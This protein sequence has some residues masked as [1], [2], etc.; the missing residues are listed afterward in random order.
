[1]RAVLLG[2]ISYIGMTALSGGP[3]WADVVTDGTMGRRG[4]VRGG[5]DVTVRAGLGQLRGTNLFHS[6]ER[7]G[8][9]EGGKVTFTGPDGVT[10]VIAR[11]TGGE[12]SDILGTLASTMPSADFF[13]INPAGILFGPNAKLDLK[14]SFHASTADQLRLADGAVFSAL[15]TAGSTLSVAE[16][17]SFGFLGAA[18]GRITLDRGTLAVAPGRHLSLSAGEVALSGGRLVAGDDPATTTVEPGGRITLAG[19]DSGTLDLR[20]GDVG[21][22]TGGSVHLS[23]GA[24]L[25]ASGDGGGA[26]RIRATDISLAEQS[27]IFASSLGDRPA[28]DGIDVAGSRLT[29]G[30]GSIIAA[31]VGRLASTSKD[32]TELPAIAAAGDGGRI[33][34]AVTEAR[35]DGGSL[36]RSTSF[37][38][39]AAGGIRI[40]A[41]NP[42]FGDGYLQLRSGGRIR[43][44]AN[45]GS[46]GNA[47]SIDV[48]VHGSLLIDAQNA[49]DPTDIGSFA[50]KDSQGYGGSISVEAHRVELVHRGEIV[51]VTGGSRAGGGITMSAGSLFLGD[52]GQ[53]KSTTRGA[54]D[55]GSIAIVAGEVRIDGVGEAEARANDR[56]RQTR[57]YSGAEAGSSGRGGTIALRVADRL[58]LNDA[59]EISSTTDRDSR[60]AAGSITI[61]AGRLYAMANGYIRA[62]TG[63]RM[64][65]GDVGIVAD[66]VTLANGGRITS[67][68]VE[69]AGDS[70]KI[71]LEA[72]QSLSLEDG[73]IGVNSTAGGNAGS[74]VIATPN[75]MLSGGRIRSETTA[76]G[77]AGRI[78]ISTGADGALSGTVSIT[79]SKLR[80]SEVTASTRGSGQGGQVS[81]RTGSLTMDGPAIAQVD[82]SDAETRVSSDASFRGRAGAV[83]VI[84]RD[85]VIG[86]GARISSGTDGAG[87][88]GNVSL[89]ATSITL[90]GGNVSSSS[91]GTLA[92][93]G[94]AGSIAITA[95]RSIL[96]D[97]GR[98]ASSSEGPGAGG[99]VVVRALDGGTVRLTEGGTIAASGTGAGPAGAVTV[100]A[101]IVEA[102]DGAIT[103]ASN[104][105]GGSIRVTAS[106][107]AYLRR[108]RIISD[109]I[110]PTSGASIVRVD[111]PV[112]VLSDSQ[113]SS[114]TADGIVEGSGEAK[115]FGVL[116][117]ISGDSLVA[118]SSATV[119]S[120]LQ[121]NLGSDLQLSPG[122]FLDVGSL[123]QP[124][125]ADRGAARS[126]FTRSGRGG[127]PAAPD[128]PL[129]S[130]GAD[131]A[132]VGRAAAGGTVFVDACA[133]SLVPETKS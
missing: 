43:S 53:I 112:I 63:N 40:A 99:D 46:T 91:T 88:A 94:D 65:A 39:G 74:I 89:A 34:V 109:G 29:L 97:G 8:I 55:A 133:G 21:A 9:A 87:D 129:P 82:G 47:G 128:R 118:G 106:D 62:N 100:S 85:V 115:V 69:R 70:G 110:V 54:A 125:C 33:S 2:T 64:P 60:G 120:G 96:L 37:G 66:K 31:D 84:A 79:S 38:G 104:A 35:I 105:E 101:G 20:S 42:G 93:A 126:T 27:S 107:W 18:A 24:A 17:Q 72:R 6:F 75:L 15:D 48:V 49:S 67:N 10:N 132:G 124:S 25:D 71:T 56:I 92:N 98:I 36:I 80:P 28:V 11:V 81:I 116:S 59:G 16:P 41:G 121:T 30:G 113:I 7:F 5:P 32:G 122:I 58:D 83:A 86:A 77:N 119:I 52:G 57:I 1:M 76:A 4:V 68:S 44:S 130:A 95:G 131:A 14:G 114:I 12:R 111:A 103:T 90:A 23:A 123:L 51:S 50:F 108:S 61:D 22:A 45:A 78:D 127:V 13:L 3:V 102:S 117:V 26:I 19:L 73:R